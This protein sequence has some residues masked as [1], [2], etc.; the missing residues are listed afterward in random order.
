MSGLAKGLVGLVAALHVAFLVMEM[1]LWTKPL[2]RK[3]FQLNQYG[4]DFAEKS[5]TLAANMGL[6]NGFLALGLFW[7]LWPRWLPDG[8][9]VPVAMFFLLCVLIAGIFGAITVKKTILYFQAFPAAAALL[10]VIFT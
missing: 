8:A 3:I 10:A 7:S 5:K 1:F 2:G 6:Y 4:P 9:A